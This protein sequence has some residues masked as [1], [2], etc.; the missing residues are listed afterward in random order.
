MIDWYLRSSNIQK[1]V[2]LF[3]VTDQYKNEII[4][5]THVSLSSD[6]F[7]EANIGL[8]F[9]YDRIKRLK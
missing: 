8:D 7:D 1:E 6:S 5:N 9:D 4:D 3:K 2:D